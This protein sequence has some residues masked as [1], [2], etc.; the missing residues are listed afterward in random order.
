MDLENKSAKFLSVSPTGKAPVVVADGASLYEFNDVN[1]Y[2][3]EVFK[4][5]KLLPE[6]PKERAYARIRMASPTTT[7]SQLCSWRA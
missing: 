5:P 3:D 6:D 1:Q 2:L 7:S 4:L